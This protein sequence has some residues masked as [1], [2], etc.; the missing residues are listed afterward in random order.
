SRRLRRI[1][2]AHASR[3]HHAKQSASGAAMGQRSTTMHEAGDTDGTSRTIPR[4]MM[5][6][7]PRISPVSPS[8]SSGHLNR[9]EQ[10]GQQRVSETGERRRAG[11]ADARSSGQPQSRL[12]QPSRPRRG[13]EPRD[14]HNA[15]GLGLPDLPESGS[16]WRWINPNENRWLNEDE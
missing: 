4:R 6:K 1:L 15:N 12:P 7:G 8:H 13:A 16:S 9:S 11:N 2:T 5:G 3:P 14:P 10:T